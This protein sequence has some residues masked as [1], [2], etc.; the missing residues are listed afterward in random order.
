MTDI[1]SFVSIRC[2]PQ[3]VI[4]GIV[5]VCEGTFSNSEKVELFVLTRRRLVLFQYSRVSSKNGIIVNIPLFADLDNSERHCV[6]LAVL[7]RM[8]TGNMTETLMLLYYS[9]DKQTFFTHYQQ[10]VAMMYF[11]RDM[12]GG[13][14]NQRNA[15]IDFVGSRTPPPTDSVHIVPLELSNP[16][17][18]CGVR[19]EQN[20]NDVVL[21][22]GVRDET[23]PPPQHTD[24]ETEQDDLI[25]IGDLSSLDTG[26]YVYSGTYKSIEKIAYA[27]T[28]P[29]QR[30]H[31]AWSMIDFSDV[32]RAQVE[33]T[34]F[35][36]DV[37]TQTRGTP[38]PYVVLPLP[39]EDY[40]QG[41][42]PQLSLEPKSRSWSTT[43]PRTF[44]LLHADAIQR[45]LNIVEAFTKTK[46]Q[47]RFHDILE[48][49]F[50]DSFGLSLWVSF[51]S[52]QVAI[53]D[54][55]N[56]CAALLFIG[57]RGQL[58]TAPS[59]N[60]FRAIRQPVPRSRRAQQFPQVFMSGNY[61]IS[62]MYPANVYFHTNVLMTT[63]FDLNTM[64]TANFRQLPQVF[65]HWLE[66]RND[67]AYVDAYATSVSVR[68]MDV[69]L[70]V[71]SDYY[72]CWV[73]P[74]DPRDNAVVRRFLW[75]LEYA[76]QLSDSD[77]PITDM[78]ELLFDLR[79]D[80]NNLIIHGRA[81]T[82]LT[83]LVA[84]LRERLGDCQD[85][86]DTLDPATGDP[87]DIATPPVD[88][89]YVV[90]LDMPNL[91]GRSLFYCY[92]KS[93]II[94]T[95]INMFGEL[96][97]DRF[98]DLLTFKL[99]FSSHEQAQ[100]VFERIIEAPTNSVYVFDKTDGIADLVDIT[101]RN[102][103]LVCTLRE[104]KALQEFE[105][106]VREDDTPCRSLCQ[107]TKSQFGYQSTQMKR[108]VFGHT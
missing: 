73:P 25:D 89:M 61:K 90:R 19:I 87:L 36:S 16:T 4:D 27:T 24:L 39:V 8:T 14:D 5:S 79:D 56:D 3:L 48:Y 43:T 99:Y 18:A 82:Y 84:D 41:W 76:V 28:F 106:R 105:Q 108:R 69:L 102:N 63:K 101:T 94:E 75:M 58:Q 95:N 23:M 104:S 70:R 96:K 88:I 30:Q 98:I 2:P 107:Q 17:V 67:A 29:L 52:G 62:E 34:H 7:P 47:N 100:Q 15:Y 33:T 54:I 44:E 83:I 51:Q 10:G 21:F 40:D 20:G 92:N 46:M 6:G 32:F 50:F 9:P 38:N 77:T 1:A 45:R 13:L 66:H 59:N 55:V 53:I 74:I 65:M 93:T 97:H 42:L 22:I 57:E 86:I 31:V 81:R 80:D 35:D 72:A 78:L 68:S 11:H 85:N 91:V 60:Q 103:G 37:P 26:L 49:G 12:Y 71:F 64:D